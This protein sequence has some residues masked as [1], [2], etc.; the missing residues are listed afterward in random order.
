MNKSTQLRLAYSG[1]VSGSAVAGDAT[2][3]GTVGAAGAA[4]FNATTHTF[5]VEESRGPLAG[6][7]TNLNLF[8]LQYVHRGW[9]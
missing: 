4:P 3:D 6:N 7:G 5:A 9:R 2:F 8:Q 1:T